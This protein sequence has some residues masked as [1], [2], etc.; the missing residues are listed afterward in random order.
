MHAVDLDSPFSAEPSA[1]APALA[2]R[3][4]STKSG[5]SAEGFIWQNSKAA[6]R[7]K[8]AELY[9]SGPLSPAEPNRRN[10]AVPPSQFHQEL[11][12]ATAVSSGRRH[13]GGVRRPLQCRQVQR[14]ER[15]HRPQ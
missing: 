4:Q 10:A 8:G 5:A 13:G 11:L 2:P 7:L 12:A 6:G 1:S 3:L 15:H 14:A 9:T